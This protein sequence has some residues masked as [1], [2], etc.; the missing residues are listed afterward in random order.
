MARAARNIE[1]GG[2]ERER[3]AVHLR[4]EIFEDGERA[5]GASAVLM[6][7]S[8]M[9]F[10]Q[11]ETEFQLWNDVSG[12]SNDGVP[13][14]TRTSGSPMPP[15]LPETT[16]DAHDYMGH[17]RRQ[18]G[19]ATTAEAQRRDA[20]ARRDRRGHRHGAR[21]VRFH[22]LRRTRR[23]RSAEAFLPRD[24]PDL[25]AARVAR[26]V[27]RRPGG[28]AARRDHLRPPRRQAR[29]AQPDARHR[30]R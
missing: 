16:H 2:D 10:P 11:Y 7:R 14:P 17:P 3:H 27:R 18:R 15:R 5:L 23:D 26:D 21:M 9:D 24:G 1:L 28:A 8:R 29:P 25:R 30:Q 13:A 4:R 22:A 12:A 19:S 6:C 20:H